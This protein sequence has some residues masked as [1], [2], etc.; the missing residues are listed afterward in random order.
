M[1][2]CHC[3]HCHSQ[4]L[5]D[6]VLD[7]PLHQNQKKVCHCERR[8]RYGQKVVITN[9]AEDDEGAFGIQYEENGVKKCSSKKKKKIMCNTE[10]KISQKRRDP[11]M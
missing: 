1:I 7:L 8:D 10:E 3:I 5:V 11:P 4:L 2:L 9:L 6:F